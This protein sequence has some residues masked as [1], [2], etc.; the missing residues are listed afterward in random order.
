MN[1]C[2]YRKRDRIVIWHDTTRY[3]LFPHGSVR[4][5][6]PGIEFIVILHGFS[7]FE[8]I[9]IE[10]TVLSCQ[11]PA[12]RASFR[13]LKAHI[14]IARAVCCR[15]STSRYVS[16]PEKIVVYAVIIRQETARNSF[17]KLPTKQTKVP[18]IH[19]KV[20]KDGTI[21]PSMN[22]L[23]SSDIPDASCSN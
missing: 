13:W 1:D 7:S 8:I 12:Y 3:R 22:T 2:E 16:P 6:K 10:I 20:L 5:M 14:G 9:R 19:N 21:D 4:N 17:G 15:N 23:Y 18:T 11:V